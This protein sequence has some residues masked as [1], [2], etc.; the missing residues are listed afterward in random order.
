MFRA[1]LAYFR[2]FKVSYVVST[3]YDGV[4]LNLASPDA[5]YIELRRKNEKFEETLTAYFEVGLCWADRGNHQ[6]FRIST[7]GILSRWSMQEVSR[8]RCLSNF[9]RSIKHYLYL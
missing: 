6:S 8:R 7:Q 3:G 2:V 9:S 1:R 5:S 4:D